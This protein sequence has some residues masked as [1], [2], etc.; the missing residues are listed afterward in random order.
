MTDYEF[1]SLLMQTVAAMGT[2]LA[3]F[4]AGV[5]AMLVVGYVAAHRLD[6]IAATLI[7]IVYTIFCV[8]MFAEAWGLGTN[9]QLLSSQIA[10]QAQQ[11]G[12]TLGWHPAARGASTAHVRYT[13]LLVYSIMYAGTL[14]FFFRMRATGGIDYEP[15]DL[16]PAASEA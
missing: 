4:M 11:P 8:G 16:E 15:A 2:S 10:A 1:A 5:F 9:L 13:G 12:S 6:R 7:V 3:N 14:W